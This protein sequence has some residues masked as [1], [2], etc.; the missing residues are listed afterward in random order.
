MGESPDGNVICVYQAACAASIDQRR[1]ALNTSRLALDICALADGLTG[2]APNGM[3][4]SHFYG[5]RFLSVLFLTRCRP[6]QRSYMK[7]LF[8]DIAKHR[9][10]HRLNGNAA[11]NFSLRRPC[12]HTS[13]EMPT[14][15]SSELV[16]KCD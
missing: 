8:K 6:G 1:L 12:L 11:I 4:I 16:V 9:M 7:R 10:P 2:T 5:Y 3:G 14:G 13:R 15:H